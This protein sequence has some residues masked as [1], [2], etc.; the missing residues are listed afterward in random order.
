MKT[1]LF[2]LS[3]A[4][5]QILVLFHYAAS[6]APHRGV[7]R[8]QDDFLGFDSLDDGI[9]PFGAAGSGAFQI[10]SDLQDSLDEYVSI[11]HD[12]TVPYTLAV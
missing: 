10:D 4:I 5:F 12:C 7:A 9:L 2:W 11:T 6:A 3:A 8:R 1:G